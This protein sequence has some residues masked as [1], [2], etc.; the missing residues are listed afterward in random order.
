M[1][2]QSGQLVQSLSARDFYGFDHLDIAEYDVPHF[3]GES[4]EEAQDFIQAVNKRA[5]AAGKQKDR[6]WI[7]GFAYPFFSRKALV[8]YDGLDEGTQDDWKLLRSAILAEFTGQQP[9]PSTVPSAA[10][11]AIR[12]SGSRYTPAAPPPPTP[13]KMIGRIRV[14]SEVPNRRGYLTV[15]KTVLTRGRFCA[16]INEASVFEAD[17]LGR[18]LTGEEESLVIKAYSKGWTLSQGAH[19]G[20]ITRSSAGF[21]NQWGNTW[22][23]SGDGNIVMSSLQADG[24]QCDSK[25]VVHEGGS[26]SDILIPSSIDPFLAF[27]KGYK[28]VTLHFDPMS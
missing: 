4:A 13:T 24:R 2:S 27:H 10:P 7:A 3:T 11:A 20:V 5:Y 25:F 18:T 6:A 14:D 8:W 22:S 1:A 21:G 15:P 26:A 17:I 12:S 9:A 28:L 23:V 16:T 19:F